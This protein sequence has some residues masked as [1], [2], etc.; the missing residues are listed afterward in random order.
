MTFACPTYNW[1]KIL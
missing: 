1:R